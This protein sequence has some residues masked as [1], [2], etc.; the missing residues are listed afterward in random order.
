M[1]SQMVGGLRVVLGGN[2]ERM[3]Y[4]SYLLNAVVGICS[5]MFYYFIICLFL[6]RYGCR[7]VHTR[8]F[9]LCRNVSLMSGIGIS[10]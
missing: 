8:S 9:I 4:V 10:C 6:Q 1:R 7:G 5:K 3:L 2:G